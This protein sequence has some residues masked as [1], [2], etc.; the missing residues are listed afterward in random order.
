MIM[1]IANLLQ[2]MLHLVVQMPL[3]VIQLPGHIVILQQPVPAMLVVS[4]AVVLLTIYTIR[5]L[6]YIH[7]GSFH[8]R[9]GLSDCNS[10]TTVLYLQS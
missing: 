7:F 1:P 10:S 9:A 8:H 4:V 2:Q 3:E 6:Q 5:R